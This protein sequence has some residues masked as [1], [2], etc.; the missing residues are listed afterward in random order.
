[1]KVVVFGVGVW[2]IVFVGYLVVWY[3][4]FLWVCDVVFIV[5]L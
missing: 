3:D 2:G 1:M 5:G 4:M